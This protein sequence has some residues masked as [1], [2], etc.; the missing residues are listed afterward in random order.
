MK[1]VFS[2]RQINII[3]TSGKIIIEKGIAGL[4][5]KNLAQEMNF[6]E[7][8]L[9]RHF[10]DK[11]DIILLLIK[12]LSNNVKERFEPILASELGPEEKLKQLFKSQLSFF[13]SNPHFIVIILCDLMLDSS[14]NIRNEILKLME[15][16]VKTIKGVVTQGQKKDVFKSEINP[17]YIVHFLVG[18]FR[19]LVLNW[20]V[21]RFQYNIESQGMKTMNHLIQLIKK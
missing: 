12:F 8:A 15:N 19:L 2:E 3:E 18:S 17:E 20:K 16:N 21:A 13:N 7:S 5:T 6:S 1:L 9:Y 4:T 14:E 11:E 10:K